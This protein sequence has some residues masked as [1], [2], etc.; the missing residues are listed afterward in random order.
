M[1]SI[2]FLKPVIDL[3][4][5]GTQIK[6][7]RKQNGF[8]VRNLQDIFGFEFPQAIYSWEQGKNVP[9]VDNLLVLARLFNVSIDEIIMTRIVEVDIVCSAET[10]A[11][12]CGK[13]CD[14]CK[15][16]LSA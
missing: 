16:K 5:T 2:K 9:T 6:A 4:G 3:K 15:Y 11:K 13:N 10:A 7:L 8:S 14:S 12:V 1:E